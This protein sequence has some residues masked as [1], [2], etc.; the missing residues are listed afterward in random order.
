MIWTLC[1]DARSSR[2][3]LIWQGAARV[4]AIRFEPCGVESFHPEDIRQR[5]CHFCHRW[6]ETEAPRE[7]ESETPRSA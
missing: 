3:R 7:V 6:I 5:Y 1:H 2:Y 4:P